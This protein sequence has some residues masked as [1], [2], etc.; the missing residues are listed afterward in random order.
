MTIAPTEELRQGAI[1]FDGLSG[2]RRDVALEFDAGLA[3]LEAGE[4][5]ATWSYAAIRSADAPPGRRRFRSLD[6]PDLA[7]LEVTEGALADR[8]A[9]A[10]PNLHQGTAIVA[11]KRIVFWS[12]AAAASILFIVFVGVPLVAD[13]LAPL[14]P[15]AVERRIG[16]A[17]E[18]QVQTIFGRRLC[19]EPAGRAAL[20]KL[21]AALGG[22]A[23]L[24]LPRAA[25]IANPIPNA[26]ALPG[27]K[28]FIFQ[29]LLKVADSPD[30]LAGVLAHEL[31]HVVNRDG[32]RRLIQT[33]GT[34]FFIGLLFG[35][36]TGSGAALFAAR[37]LLEASYSR[38]AERRADAFAITT[39]V[40]LGRSPAPLGELLVRI[41]GDERDAPLSILANHP[42]TGERL[43]MLKRA[44]AAP[45][46]GPPLLSAEEWDKLRAIC[47]A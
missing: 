32:M 30:E 33:G 22:G 34:S 17:V 26:I 42:L 13:R 23:G 41:T 19:T 35:D 38:D 10:A 44:A 45:A 37:Q 40:G 8:L 36:V 39:M 5:I 46:N 31:G 14:I 29:G 16:D 9:A 25:I 3:I 2:M 4:A 43:D 24:L 47:G 15:M 12:I 27:G 1:Y 11:T 21:L 7:R 20:D 18:A 28:V 6:A